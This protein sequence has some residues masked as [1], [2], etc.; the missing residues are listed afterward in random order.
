[1]TPLPFSS[2]QLY[3]INH[4]GGKDSQAMMIH[5]LEQVP[6]SNIVVVHASLGDVEWPGALEHAKKQAD[7]AGVP[8][9]VARAKLS[10]LEKVLHRF[11]TRPTAPSWPSS[12]ARW[13]T[14]DLK[15]GPIQRE[16]RRYATTH[17]FRTVVNC[18]GLRAEEST[19]RAKKCDFTQNSTQTNGQ[20]DWFE[21]LPIHKWSLGEV[22]SCVRNAGQQL[23]WAYA[24]GNERF[25]CIFCF[26]GSENDWINGAR[27][28]PGVA[29]KVIGMEARTGYTLSMNKIPLKEIVGHVLPEEAA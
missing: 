16:V 27:H 10:L 12:Q 7:A 14:S 9:L 19:S 24:T 3:V 15:R 28:N 6:K 26:F 5:V 13:C 21:W 22:L 29:R 2:D 20:R 1:M 11:L 25:S 4:S 23:H 8:F 18:M 17:G